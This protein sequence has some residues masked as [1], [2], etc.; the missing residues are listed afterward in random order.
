MLEFG[1]P[2][3]VIKAW[4]G[5][6]QRGG[7]S[8][9]GN[10]NKH[11]DVEMED[12]AVYDAED[13]A[14]PMQALSALGPIAEDE[15]PHYFTLAVRPFC[16]VLRLTLRQPKIR[17]MPP[18]GPQYNP[19]LTVALTAIEQ[20]V[21]WVRLAAFSGYIVRRRITGAEV[22]AGTEGRFVLNSGPLPE[23]GCVRNIEG[24]NDAENFVEEDGAAASERGR[25]AWS[26]VQVSR[27]EDGNRVLALP[28]HPL[29]Q[30][31]RDLLN[32]RPRRDLPDLRHGSRP[33][34]PF[35]R[36]GALYVI[37]DNG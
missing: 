17:A 28:K 22:G 31:P 13:L 37:R 18:Y 9:T 11:R 34:I 4:G 19:F 26:L 20:H 12:T 23:E 8:S 3:G 16:M 15:L 1:R 10:A 29:D 21:P 35:S 24:G 32:Y 14:R 27:P 33:G 25:C 30:D 2:D 7:R 5:L 36:S 6:A